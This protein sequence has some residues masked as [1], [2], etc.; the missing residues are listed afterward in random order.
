MCGEREGVQLGEAGLAEELGALGESVVQGNGLQAILDHGAD[1]DEAHAVREERP[2][3]AGGGIRHPDG[4]EAIVAQQ[5]EAMPGVA[6]IRLRLAHDHGAHLRGIADEQRVP[7][8]LHEGV[9][10]DGVPGA[11]NPDGHRPGQGG[12][13]LFHRHPGVDELALAH[14]P[15]LGV[16]HGHLLHARVQVASH[17]CHGVGPLSGSAVA[18]AEHSNSARPFS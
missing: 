12:I 2:Q 3:I 7:E 1:A 16:Q 15:G 6:P 17:E 9:K 8:A 5:V 13:E 18:H 14:L 11:L 4:E 10:P